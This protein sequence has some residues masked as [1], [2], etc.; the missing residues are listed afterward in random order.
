MTCPI[1]HGNMLIVS[2]MG[3]ITAVASANAQGLK[4]KPVNGSEPPRATRVRDE[5]TQRM[6]NIV[7][8]PVPHR[9]DPMSSS[10]VSESRPG[11]FLHAPL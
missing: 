10:L 5:A 11:G 3:P 1:R 6:V 4:T 7:T 2:K 9:G 8:H